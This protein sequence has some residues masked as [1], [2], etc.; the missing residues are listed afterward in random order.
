MLH[1]FDA[2]KFHGNAARHNNVGNYDDD[3]YD[4]DDNGEFDSMRCHGV[5]KN[6]EWVL[7]HLIYP[8]KYMVATHSICNSN[9]CNT[10]NQI[11]FWRFSQWVK[12][13]LLFYKQNAGRKL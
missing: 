2:R 10:S 8:S 1:K 6:Y 5:C 4:D 13:W 12:L 9:I 11:K 3:D 7:D